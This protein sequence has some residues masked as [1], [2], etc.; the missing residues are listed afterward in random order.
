MLFQGVGSARRMK[1]RE[2]MA[3]WGGEQTFSRWSVLT[4]VLCVLGVR[5][6][7]MKV[8]TCQ[9]A[10]A[11]LALVLPCAQAFAPTYVN[12]RSVQLRAAKSSAVSGVPSFLRLRNHAVRSL[13][14]AISDEARISTSGGAGGFF[15]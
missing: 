9:L 8:G 11:V 15:T 7:K 2:A 6:S 13:Q 10:A 1:K 14:M 3:T 12:G 4:C 5:R